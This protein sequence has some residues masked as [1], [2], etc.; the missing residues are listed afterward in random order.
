[1]ISYTIVYERVKF[2]SIDK[3]TAELIEDFALQLNCKKS[4]YGNGSVYRFPKENGDSWFVEVNPYDGLIFSDAYFTLLKPFT[5]IYN[6]PENHILMCSLYSGNITIIENGK[7]TRHLYQG[8]HLLINRGKELK[9]I[10]GADKPVW[11]TFSLLKEDFMLKNMN[12]FSHYLSDN[13]VINPNHYN[14]PELL[15][16]F[17]QL[18]YAIRRS[19]L[20]FVYY[21]GKMYE[22]FSIIARNLKN[23]N[24]LNISRH[25]HLSYQNMQFIWLLKDEIDKNILNPPTLE[26][27]KSLTEMSESKLRRC[28]KATYDKTIH[29]YIRHKKMEQAL[30]FL[31]H[32]D[33]SIHNISTTLGYE[34]A[35]KFSAAF[36]KVYG[37]TPSSFRKSFDL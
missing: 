2:M 8:I 32:D 4:E 6:V 1:M 23:E 24:F 20:P 11:Y 29:E 34:S 37:I 15:M 17:E 21:L 12:D 18:K 13:L 19:D 5:Y 25:N 16:I 3:K 28:F 31:S 10:I 26:E 7:K 27:M 35:S 22:I 30:R 14:T 33:M 9:I 36:K